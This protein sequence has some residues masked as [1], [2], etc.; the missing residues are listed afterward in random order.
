M[1]RKILVPLSNAAGSM[2]AALDAALFIGR[3]FGARVEVLYA[4]PSPENLILVL[5]K[6]FAGTMLE[7]A[8]REVQAKIARD[9]QAA[10][11]RMQGHLRQAAAAGRDPEI[12]W[13]EVDGPADKTIATEGRFADL[14]L[15]AKPKHDGVT[16]NVWRSMFDAALFGTARPV[17]L[18]PFTAVRPIGSRIMIAWNGSPQATRA[19]VAALPLLRHAQE[20]LIGTFGLGD[21]IH[22]DT[23]RLQDYL[24]MQGVEAKA[25][26]LPASLRETGSV[27]LAM[28]AQFGADL[29]VMGGHGRNRLRQWTLGSTT[30]HVVGLATIPVLM[31]H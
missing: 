22:A 14:L 1:Y 26:H 31:V 24:L 5:G 3:V 23:E 6:G 12:V 4:R 27:L 2:D 20:V 17:I 7:N 11:E 13:R 25:E 16:D 8:M 21:D 9:C 19:M 10:H 29:L 28:A 15:F 30:S 18:T